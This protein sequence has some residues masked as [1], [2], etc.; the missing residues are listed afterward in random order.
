MASFGADFLDQSTLR[1]LG[2]ARLGEGVLVHPTVVIIGLENLSIGDQSRID[3]FTVITANGPISIGRNVHIGSGSF[4]AGAGG[5]ELGDF[6][7][8]SQGVRI[9]SVTDDFSGG[10]MIGPTLPKAYTAVRKAPV[11]LGRH[12]VLGSG[13]TVLP[14]A[15]IGEGS[16]V[17]AMSLVTRSLPPWGVYAG[18][19][20]RLIRERR[21][22][23]LE[24]EAQYMASL[25]GGGD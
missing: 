1:S 22:D 8:L 14:G 5:I 19:P 20:A 25:S 17:G 24:L 3:P 2:F 7:N 12:G 10:A 15:D 21:R 23:L 6:A 13:A 18:A 16:A 4:M 11:V 9:Y